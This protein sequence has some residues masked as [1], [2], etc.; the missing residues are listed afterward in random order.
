M[1][2]ISLNEALSA[3][4]QDKLVAVPVDDKDKNS[5]WLTEK[6]PVINALNKVKG[7]SPYKAHAGVYTGGTNGVYWTKILEKTSPNLVTIENLYSVGKKELKRVMSPVEVDLLH[8]LLRSGD[9]GRWKWKSESYVIVPHTPVTSW[10]AIHESE[11][12]SKFPQTYSYFAEFRDVLLKRPD[13]V[14]RRKRYPFY[15]MFNAHRIS[16]MP[17]KVAWRRIASRMEAVV[18]GPLDDINIGRKVPVFQE[19]LSYI[20][21]QDENEAHFLCAILNSFEVDLLVRSFSQLGGK[22]FATPSVLEQIRIPKYDPM[23]EAHRKL[24]ELSRKAHQLTLEATE[25]ELAKVE[26]EINELVGQLYGL[27]DEELE[28]IEK[29]LA[30]L[31]GKWVEEVEEAEELPALEPDVA[32]RNNIVEAGKP[33]DLEVVVGNPLEEAI[34]DVKVKAELPGRGVER[35]FQEVKGEEVIQVRLDELSE[36]QYKVKLVMD[37]NL[38]GVNRRLE[39]ELSIFI[40]G[41]P[42]RVSVDR[43]EAEKLFGGG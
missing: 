38:E 35:V 28:E 29:S 4:S 21:S 6:P 17:Y 37:Y 32:L 7:I 25:E 18:L 22:S 20:P 5:A 8:R 2:D 26:N 12:K 42:T 13:Y 14:L 24:A 39:K 10:R 36:G 33:F 3:C 41:G 27:T 19:T 11:M 31:G 23:N 34:R 40:K 15:I 30:I 1:G 16:F 43:G 9:V